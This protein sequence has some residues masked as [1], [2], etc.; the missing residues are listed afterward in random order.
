MMK[1]WCR[2]DHQGREALEGDVDFNIRQVKLSPLTMV[3]MHT[4]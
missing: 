4:E 3:K 2:K 1:G